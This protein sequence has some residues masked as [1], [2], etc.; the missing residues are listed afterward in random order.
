MKTYS[1]STRRAI[2]LASA[3]ILAM[4]IAAG[5][6]QAGNGGGYNSL[7]LSPGLL[8]VSSSNYDPTQGALSTLQIGTTLPNS[9]TAT[10][11][12]VATNNYVTVWNNASVDGSFG[13]TSPI[14]LSEVDPI[15]G[16]VFRHAQLPTSQVVTSFSSKSE[17]GLHIVN[18]SRGPHLL[19]MGY[20]G[21][22]VGAL[23]V[24]NSDAVVGQ[25]PTNPVTFAFGTSHSFARAIVTM[26][27]HGH[28]AYTPTINYGGNNEIGSAHV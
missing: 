7:R 4:S 22:G 27:Q 17:L 26:D 21:P 6:A 8:V 15:N 11:Q 23:D 9:A 20:A 13:V 19:F 24:S 10:T 5:I 2:R 14:E 18:D 3:S 1:Q 25:D 16:R 12:A 28:F